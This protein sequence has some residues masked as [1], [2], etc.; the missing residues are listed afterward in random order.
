MT[1]A[2]ARPDVEETPAVS[3][4][5]P[6]SHRRAAVN[7]ARVALLMLFIASM[8][9]LGLGIAALVLGDPPEVSGWLR[10]VFGT[11][12][13]YMAIAMA[14]VLGAPAAV[15][16]WAMAGANA[17]D[18][19]PALSR[20]GHRGAAAL[21]SLAVVATAVV[22]LAFGTGISF[23]DLAFV[24]IVALQSFGLAGAVS[25]SPHRM[26][27]VLAGV[28]LLLVTAGALWVLIR[29]YIAASG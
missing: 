2:A 4:D 6:R 16:V 23:L 20:L 10:S 24:G 22:M 5:Q 18:A 3:V 25:F 7:G 12:F 1:T 11:V 27:A 21:A 29:A 9:L 19:T 26:R 15:G 13:G 28:A 14:V 8:A 17:P